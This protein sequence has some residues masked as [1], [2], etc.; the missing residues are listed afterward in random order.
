MKKVVYFIYGFLFFLH[1]QQSFG[2][3]EKTYITPPSFSSGKPDQSKPD[4]PFGGEAA[5]QNGM[6]SY[7]IPIEMPDGVNG[8][9]P[10]LGVN[11]S[12]AVGNGLLG[13]GWSLSGISTV[14]RGGKNLTYDN[15]IASI[16]LDNQDVLLG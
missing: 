16:R 9:Q 14:S 1:N 6:A 8:F 2:Q 10:S 5:I 13:L 3:I 15:E 4:L 11:Y 12:S 7:I